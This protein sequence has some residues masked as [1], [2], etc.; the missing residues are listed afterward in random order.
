MRHLGFNKFLYSLSRLLLIAGL[1]CTLGLLS[2]N[3]HVAYAADEFDYC[4]DLDPNNPSLLDILCPA[5]RIFN[6]ALFSAGA[7]F[8]AMIM[9]GAY[10]YATSLGDPKAAQGANLTMTYAVLGLVAV[11][12]VF[13]ILYLVLN[14]LGIDLWDGGLYEQLRNMI[15][16]IFYNSTADGQNIVEIPACAGFGFN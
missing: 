7:V 5:V 2:P 13:T 15:C 3:A 12:G 8:V 14:I 10:K 16:S 6:I 11:L 1:F 9:I 4:E